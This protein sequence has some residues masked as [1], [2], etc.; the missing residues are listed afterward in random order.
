MID[1]KGSV[2]NGQND[3]GRIVTNVGKI[4]KKALGADIT[5]RL[6]GASP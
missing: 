4:D 2:G 3:P 5:Q 6:L 1:S